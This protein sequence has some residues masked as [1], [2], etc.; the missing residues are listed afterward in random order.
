[1]EFLF[2]LNVL[3]LPWKI[4]KKFN[5]NEKIYDSILVLFVSAVLGLVGLVIWLAGI[6]ALGYG[7]IL[8]FQGNTW[9]ICIGISGSG[10]LLI[11]FGSLFTL[12]S[13]EFSK[14]S[15]SNKI[16]AYAACIIALVSCVLTLAAMF[17]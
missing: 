14:V 1:M 10:F 16:Y 3:F 12:A 6:I 11:I 15:D 13:Q 17:K 2:I 7:V 4:S 8:L 9:H 5:I